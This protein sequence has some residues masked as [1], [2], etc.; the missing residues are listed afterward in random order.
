MVLLLRV[1]AVA[2]YGVLPPALPV[3][4]GTGWRVD[5]GENNHTFSSHPAK[6]ASLTT[7]I[8]TVVSNIAINIASLLQFGCNPCNAA[9]KRKQA[10]GSK[11]GKPPVEQ[12]KT[13]VA[14]SKQDGK[15]R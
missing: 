7:N 12:L 8:P 15:R 5:R 2:G 14:H 4:Q 6:L 10:P 1:P 9:R 13:S 3:V 11:P